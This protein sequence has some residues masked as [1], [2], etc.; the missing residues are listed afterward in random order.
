MMKPY[1]RLCNMSL[2]EARITATMKKSH[3]S[4]T[5]TILHSQMIVSVLWK[6]HDNKS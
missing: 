1:I 6:D 4:Q 3:T 2:Q 5:K